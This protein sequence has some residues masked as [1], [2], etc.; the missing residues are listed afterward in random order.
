MK[1]EGG[2]PKLIYEVSYGTQ[3]VLNLLINIKT[4]FIIAVMSKRQSFT[5]T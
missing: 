3:K 5:Q 4:I 2:R 1:M